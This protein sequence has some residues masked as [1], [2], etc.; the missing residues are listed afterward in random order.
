MKLLALL[1]LPITAFAEDYTIYKELALK[2]EAGEV[3]LTVTEC[4]IINSQGFNYRAYATD[5]AI[6]H[7]GCWSIDHDIINI[8]FYQEEQA[9][10][11][12]FR[13]HLFTPKPTL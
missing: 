11:A 9:L 1:L 8:I 3:V 5:G 2:T 4:P 13:K 12:T 10:M 6:I 7:E